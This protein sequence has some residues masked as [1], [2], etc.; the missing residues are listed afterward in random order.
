M[1]KYILFLVGPTCVGKT[2][3]SISLI[4][5]YPLEIINMDSVMVYKYMDIGTS[6]PNKKILKKFN[7][8]LI[9]ICDPKFDYSVFNFCIDAINTI[10]LCW[11]NKKIP[12][13]VGGSM[14]YFNLLYNFLTKLNLN[15]FSIFYKK[16]KRNIEILQNFIEKHQILYFDIKIFIFAI[17]PFNENKLFNL[18]KKRLYN[19]IKNGF[20]EEV[21]FLYSRNDITLKCKSIKSIGYNDLWLYCDNKLTFKN[22]INST[23]NSTINLYKKQIIWLKKFKKNMIFVENKNYV[24]LNYL[25]NIIDKNLIFF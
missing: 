23:L 7:H 8:H 3:L 18:I 17:I 15:D 16:N 6:K 2:E 14:L 1:K 20:I 13:L 22:A 21:N 19:M 4:Q 24:S 25:S 10:N 11:K 12:L 9:D 5:K